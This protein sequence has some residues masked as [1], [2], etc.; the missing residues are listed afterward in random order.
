[1]RWSELQEIDL[2]DTSSWPP[3]FKVLG[4]ALAGAAILYAGY[5]FFLVPE[6]QKLQTM[7]KEEA[8]L[9]QSYLEKKGLVVNLPAYREQ[10]RE[11]RNRFGVVLKQLPDRTEVPALLIDI[12]Q[13]GLA[14]GLQFEQ[15]K[16]GN[17]LAREFYIMLP[18]NLRVIGTYHRLAEFISDIAALPR[19]VTIGNM[20]IKRQKGDEGSLLTMQAQL[21]TYH[22]VGDEGEGAADQPVRAGG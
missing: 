14:R 1:M 2:M 10:M 11:I 16:P 15:F 22:Y 18:I 5:K 12:S 9:K 21:F 17:P 19:I 6:Q 20:S 7:Q 13:A 8:Q 3:W 4:A